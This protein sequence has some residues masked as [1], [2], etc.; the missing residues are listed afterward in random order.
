MSI[1]FF[2]KYQKRDLFAEEKKDN[3]IIQVVV[4]YEIL[5][6]F[7]FDGWRCKMDENIDKCMLIIS[8]SQKNN[9]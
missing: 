4:T 7:S 1:R 8:K 5:S 3:F 9:S 2:S 6:T